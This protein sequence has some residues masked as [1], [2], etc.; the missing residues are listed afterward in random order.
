MQFLKMIDKSVS[1]SNLK[2]FWFVAGFRGFN[3]CVLSLILHYSC[4]LTI[5]LFFKPEDEVSIGVHERTGPCN[6]TSSVYTAL[7]MVSLIH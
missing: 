5:L 7:G 2:R 1:S 4:Y 3:E 6:A